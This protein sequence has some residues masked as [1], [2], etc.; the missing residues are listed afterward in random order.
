MLGMCP[1]FINSRAYCDF[2][3][4]VTSSQ[5]FNVIISTINKLYLVL[6]IFTF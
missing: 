5:C 3:A 1:L 6:I 2:V 4:Y